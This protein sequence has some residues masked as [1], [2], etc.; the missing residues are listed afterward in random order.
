MD[1]PTATLVAAQGLPMEPHRREMYKRQICDVIGIDFDQMMRDFREMCRQRDRYRDDCDRLTRRCDTLEALQKVMC[2]PANML[3]SQVTIDEY[4]DEN[5]VDL[6]EV[7]T[8]LGD[9]YVDTWPLPPQKKIVLRT[10]QRPGFAPEKIA[11]DLAF[12]NQG[13]NYLDLRIQFYLQPGGQQPLGK[14]FGPK[15][16]GNQ[17]LNKDGTQIHVPFPEYRNRAL[18]VGSLERLAVEISHTGPNNLNSAYI[19]IYH[20][21]KRFYRMCQESCDPSTCG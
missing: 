8:G 16:R 1:T 5:Q 20:D 9:P 17:F 3:Y 13:D 19:T 11:I 2:C 14:P 7:V 10:E 4:S 6:E 21:A 18:V 12:A 15:Y